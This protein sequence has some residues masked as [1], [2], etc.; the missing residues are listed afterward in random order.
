MKNYN[1]KK[2]ASLILA[3]DFKKAFDS[4]NHNYIQKVLKNFNFG[5]DICN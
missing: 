1:E 5:A 2:I 4:I 3:I